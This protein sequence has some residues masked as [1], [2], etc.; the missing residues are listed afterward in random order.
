MGRRPLPSRLDLPPG[1]WAATGGRDRAEGAVSTEK[2]RGGLRGW[3]SPGRLRAPEA[4][5]HAVE[6]GDSVD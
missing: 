5:L 4:P 2:G 3:H 6:P 1:S